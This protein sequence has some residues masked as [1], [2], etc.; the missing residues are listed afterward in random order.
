MHPEK[1]QLDEIQN[2]WLAAIIY[3]NM[4]AIWQTG[5]NS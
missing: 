5:P 2:V 4:P 3:F 1:F